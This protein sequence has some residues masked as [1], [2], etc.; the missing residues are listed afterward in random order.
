MKWTGCGGKKKNPRE[1][2]SGKGIGREKG[3]EQS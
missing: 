3:R 1:I 2:G